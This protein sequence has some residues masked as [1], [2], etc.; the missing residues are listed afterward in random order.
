MGGCGGGVVDPLLLWA[1]V[2]T[3]GPRVGVVWPGGSLCLG[4]GVGGRDVSVRRKA[5]TAASPP[6]MVRICVDPCCDGANYTLHLV[7]VG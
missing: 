2:L 4:G 5:S 1:E 3:L 6:Q 7:S